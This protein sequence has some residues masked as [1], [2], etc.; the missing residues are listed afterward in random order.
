MTGRTPP[1]SPLP[2]EAGEGSAP[3]AGA[4][5]TVAEGDVTVAAPGAGPNRPPT[6]AAA[7]DQVRRLLTAPAGD[8]PS[9]VLDDVLLVVTE[10]VTN[11]LRHGGGLTAFDARLDGGVLTVSVADASPVAPHTVPRAHAAA[12]GGFGWRIVQRLCL[13]VTVTPTA[14]GKTIEVVMAAYPEV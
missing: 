9:A 1:P 2:P 4:D 10:L 12:P 7:R 13:R 5:V 11:A 8:T 14:G 3:G 6:A